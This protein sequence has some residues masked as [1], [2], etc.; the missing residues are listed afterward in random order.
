MRRTVVRATLVAGLLTGPTGL[1]AQ[2]VAALLA[3]GDSAYDAYRPV[4]AVRAFEA[5]L[6]ID[7]L[8]FEANWKAARSMVDIAKQITGKADS[9]K[10]QR[11]SI[12]TV[13]RAYAERALRIDSTDAEGHFARALVLG[14]LS[15]TRGGKE[16]VRFARIIFDEAMRAIALDSTHDGAHHILGAWHAEVKRLSGIQKFFAKTLFGGGFLDRGNW[17]AAIAHL[18][19]AVAL[20]PEYVFHRL[21]LAQVLVDRKRYSEARALLATIPPLSQSD[22]MDEQYQRDAAALAERIRDKRD[23]S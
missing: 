9:L 7:S 1:R 14:Q 16:R 11:D 10:R 5:A 12:Y 19:R 15:R 8:R 17:E 20:R 23:G 4:E 2:D 22:V 18:E 6:A 13:A 3:A 21:E